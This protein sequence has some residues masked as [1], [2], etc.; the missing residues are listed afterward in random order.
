MACP[1]V[2]YSSS[3]ST[4][5]SFNEYLTHSD[6]HIPMSKP[7]EQKINTK[8]ILLSSYLLSLFSSFLNYPGWKVGKISLHQIPL[9]QR[10]AN[11]KTNYSL[12]LCVFSLQ[13][14]SVTLNLL[15]SFLGYIFNLLNKKGEKSKKFSRFTL[16]IISCPSEFWSCCIAL[17]CLP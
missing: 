13:E 11:L 10:K 7:K 4:L 8:C 16:R 6:T 3:L 9:L 15:P 2:I 5:T 14:N 12:I 1:R 17:F